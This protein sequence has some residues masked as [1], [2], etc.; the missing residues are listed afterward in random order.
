M[1]LAKEAQK[2]GVDEETANI[3]VGWAKNLGLNYHEILRHQGRPG[4]WGRVE[5]IKIFK[6]HIPIIE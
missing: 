5:H 3:S 1:E 6:S 2:T 4:I